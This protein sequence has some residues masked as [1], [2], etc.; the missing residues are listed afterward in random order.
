MK[1][2][3]VCASSAAS[4]TS[5]RGNAQVEPGREFADRGMVF[6]LEDELRDDLLHPGGAGLAVGGNDDVVI[7]EGEVVPDRRI[8]MMVVQLARLHGPGRHCSSPMR[9]ADRYDLVAGLT[10]NLL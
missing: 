5:F 1:R 4:F 8:E 7:A 10:S 6:A 9:W 2:R 3:W